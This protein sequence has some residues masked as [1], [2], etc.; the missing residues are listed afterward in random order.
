[1]IDLFLSGNWR[2]YPIPVSA[3]GVSVLLLGVIYFRMDIVSELSA[4]YDQLMMESKA[5]DYNAV[6]GRGLDKDLEE[7][8][9]LSGE[10]NKRLMN[11]KETADIYH[12]FFSL[13]KQVGVTIG[14]PR[15]ISVEPILPEIKET[16]SKKKSKRGKKGKAK[17]NKP[18]APKL[19][20]TEYSINASGGFHELV[21]LM[22]KLEGGYYFG[23]I[24][25]Y[26]LGRSQD[27]DDTR[28]SMN[29]NL[30][31]FSIPD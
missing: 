11:P 19:A 18:A 15:E 24:R 4:E 27:L 25:R 16:A 8:E 9:A 6:N 28:L 20:I 13:E 29:I 22:H 10:I 23:S 21:A 7:L 5:V 17:P 26:T 1:M 12:Y 2:K 14:D 30:G 3:L 31:F